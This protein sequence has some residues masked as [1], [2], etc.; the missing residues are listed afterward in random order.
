[1]AV[2]D[3]GEKLL[4]DHNLE[5]AGCMDLRHLA[6]RQESLP[7]KL[8][9]QSLALQYLSVELDKVA[10]LFLPKLKSC[11]NMTKSKFIIQCLFRFQKY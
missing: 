11:K 7:G 2:L 5:V 9:L 4:V 6:V 10:S 1:M 3:D 8:G